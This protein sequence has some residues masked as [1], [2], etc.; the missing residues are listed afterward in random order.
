MLTLLKFT[1]YR[2]GGT[3]VKCSFHVREVAGLNPGRILNMSLVK[4]DDPKLLL[5]SRLFSTGLFREPVG[6]T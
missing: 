1:E 6:R 3:M 2:L 4:T 5:V